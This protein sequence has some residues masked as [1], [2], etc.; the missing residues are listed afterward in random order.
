M[1]AT[2]EDALICDLAE[3]YHI[4]NYRQYKPKFIATLAVGLRDD[5]RI[6]MIINRSKLKLDQYVSIAILDCLKMLVWLN[7]SDATI[8][9]NRPELILDR[10]FNNNTASQV[11]AYSDPDDFEKARKAIIE[12]SKHGV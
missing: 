9:E 10:I 3:T 4:F 5:S 7:T 1:L 2:N 12:R 8:G 11:E 6:K